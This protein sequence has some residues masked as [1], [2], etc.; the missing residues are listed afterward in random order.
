MN[1]HIFPYIA[2]IHDYSTNMFYVQMGEIG[3]LAR[4]HFPLMVGRFQ[5]VRIVY[6]F[7]LKGKSKSQ[8]TQTRNINTTAGQNRL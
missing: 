3:V 7:T 2:S 8:Y 5:G 4:L 6:A 1:R